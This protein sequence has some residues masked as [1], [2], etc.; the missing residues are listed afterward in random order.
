MIQ[1][2]DR[3]SVY[4]DK[5]QWVLIE[6]YTG[7]DKDGNT[8]THTRETYHPWLGMAMRWAAECDCEGAD[9]FK[10][11]EEAYEAISEAVRGRRSALEDHLIDK[12]RE[13]ADTRDKL[14]RAKSEIK[15]LKEEAA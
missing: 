2:N 12:V 1:I 7:K 15:R 14:R 4:R 3:W 10:S 13:L 11:I 8:K 5:Y 6:T 9:S